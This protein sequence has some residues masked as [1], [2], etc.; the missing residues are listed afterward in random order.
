MK[1]CARQQQRA[2]EILACLRTSS[3]S[4]SSSSSLVGV[5]AS[6]GVIMRPMITFT[7]NANTSSSSAGAVV[8]KAERVLKS[9]ART[10]AAAIDWKSA[11]DARR[12]FRRK[13]DAMKMGGE[14]TNTMSKVRRSFSCSSSS[15]SS[16]SR[17]NSSSSSN[18]RDDNREKNKKGENDER[19][20]LSGMMFPWERAVLSSARQEG[21][22]PWWH[23]VYWFV[24]AACVL[25]IVWNRQREYF[26][27]KGESEKRER[28]LKANRRA[29]ARAIEGRSFVSEREYDPRTDSLSGKKK[30]SSNSSSTMN[31]NNNNNSSVDDDDDDDDDDELDPFEG[32]EPHEI[33]ALVQKEAP[34]GDVYSGWSPEEIQEYEEKRFKEKERE[35]KLITPIERKPN[36]A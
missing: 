22:T 27:T 24:F 13:S 11:L 12:S 23:K 25:L 16:S 34:D 32:L 28:E 8:V 4:S 6:L 36:N 26:D 18:D 30:G 2:T 5:R 7:C 35:K 3:S 10:A 15:S 33:Q 31:N 19:N 14:G 20:P 1:K 21:P 17:S 29:M 9:R